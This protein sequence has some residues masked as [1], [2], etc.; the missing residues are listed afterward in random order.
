MSAVFAIFAE[1]G[2]SSQ[3]FSVEVFATN[4]ELVRELAK[5]HG[6]RKPSRADSDVRAACLKHLHEQEIDGKWKRSGWTGRLFFSLD[7][8]SDEV[9]IHELFH[10]TMEWTRRARVKPTSG[11]GEERAACSIQYMFRQIKQK[12]PGVI[13]SHYAKSA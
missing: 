2:S 12:A 9:V 3:F 5:L 10:A 13:E 6:R 4:D 1:E 11:R 8:M 7:D